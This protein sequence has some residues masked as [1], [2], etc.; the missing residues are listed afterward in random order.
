LVAVVLLFG[1]QLWGW[2]TAPGPPEVELGDA[3]PAVA[4]AIDAARR[5]VWWNPRS[6]VAWG[7]LGQQLR[8]H[9]FVPASNQCFGHAGR[10]DPANS[11]WPYLQGTGLQSDDPEAARGHLE[12]AANLCSGTPDAPQLALADVCL[13]LGRLDEAER[14]YREVLA[15]DAGNARAHLGLGRLAVE[16]GRPGDALPHLERSASSRLT[17]Q[18]ARVLLAQAYQQLGD[19]AAADRERA[20]AVSLPVD[21]PWPDPFQEEVLALMSGKQARLARLQTLHRQGR[22]AEARELARQLEADYPDVYWLVEGRDRRKE[23]N[24]PAAERALRKAVE[25]APHSIEAHFDLGTVQFEQRNFP[26]AAVAF[27]KVTELEP[28]YG[29]AYLRLGRCLEALGDRAGAIRALQASVR[30][31]PQQAEAH[32]EL[33]ALLAREGRT[34]EAITLLRNALQL[35]PNDAKAR[36]LL[37]ELSRRAR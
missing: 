3:D 24:L 8:A 33:G 1:G 30:Y 29:P 35:Q 15:R 37:D 34:D 31:M 16:R 19:P 21:P 13:H 12:R 14:H 20:L 18:A 6:G 23:G 26:A 32:R 7:K 10:L 5:D 4:D 28:G 36:D 2:L 9:G 25:F 17:P 11:R 27:G 22:T